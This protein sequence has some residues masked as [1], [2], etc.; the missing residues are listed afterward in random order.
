LRKTSD[1]REG[2]NLLGHRDIVAGCSY[3]QDGTRLLSWSYDGTLCLWDPE[4]GDAPLRTLAGHADRVTAAALAPGGRFAVSG[5]RDTQVKVWDLQEG[6][7]VAS[8]TQAAEIRGCFFLPDGQAVVTVDA[9]GWLTCLAMPTLE[10][11]SELQLPQKVVCGDVAPAGNQ[12]A[13][14]CEDGRLS[15]IAI[16]GLDHVALPI[17]ATPVERQVPTLLGRFLGRRKTVVT[18][19][20][21]CPACHRLVEI[22]AGPDKDFPCPLCSRP[23]HL[24]GC[25]AVAPPEPLRAFVH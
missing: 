12:I 24:N 15:L 25:L 16:D 19:H 2:K 4:V 17:T 11:Q 22:A 21:T 3:T 9:N 1:E 6:E 14:G 7:E 8:V 5:G 13:L 23:L 20:F 10:M 18:Y